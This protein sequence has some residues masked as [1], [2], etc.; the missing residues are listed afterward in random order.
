MCS[1]G[2]EC[3]CRDTAT[4]CYFGLKIDV[5]LMRRLVDILGRSPHRFIVSKGPQ[6]TEFELAANRWCAEYLPQ[7]SILPHVDLV[8]CPVSR[9]WQ[10]FGLG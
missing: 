7:P 3:G 9:K 2:Y 6:H 4:L 10:G 8:I 5:E 1:P